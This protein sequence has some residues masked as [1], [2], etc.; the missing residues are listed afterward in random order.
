MSEAL[1][2]AEKATR[3]V[4]ID[5]MTEKSMSIFEGIQASSMRIVQAS[6]STACR[7]GLSHER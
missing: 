1:R 6:P 4:L 7:V 3:E 2:A 5:L